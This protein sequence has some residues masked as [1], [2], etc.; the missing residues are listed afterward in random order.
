MEGGVVFGFGDYNT[1][2]VLWLGE[3]GVGAVVFLSVLG[4]AILGLS[5]Y[6]LRPMPALRKYTLLTL[7]AVVYL[8]AVV[9]LLEPAVDLKHVT[10]VKNDIV[11]LFDASAS[12]RLEADGTPRIDLAREAFENLNLPQSG[13]DDEHNYLVYAMESRPRTLPRDSIAD[14]K[15]T[16]SDSGLGNALKW[17]SDEYAR[18]SLGGVVVISDGID[19]SSM[20]TRTKRGEPLDEISLELVK[21]LDAPINT[22]SAG[23]ASDL[24]D[25]AIRKVSHDD[26]AFVHNK[27]SIEVD[28]QVVGFTSTSI[29]VRLE[30]DGQLLQTRDL[31]VEDGKTDYRVT[32]EFVPKRLGREVY[33]VELPVLPG[34]VLQTNN[35]SYFVQRVIRDKIRVLQVVGRPSWDE[36]YLRMFLKR[37][38]NIDLISF[39]ILRTAENPDMAPASEMSL[40]P[41]PTDELFD[42]E[43]G[44][45]DLI[46]FQ[47]FNFGPYNMLRYLPNIEKFVKDG[48]GFVMVGGDLSFASGG[49]AG[50]PIED[51]LPVRLPANSTNAIDTGEFRPLLTDAGRRHPITQLAFDP[52][53]NDE[54]WGSLPPQLGTN[55]VMGPKKDATVLATHPRLSAEGKPMPVITVSEYGDGR[56]MALTTDATWRWAFTN[57]ANGGTSREYQ[58]LWN[59]TM[60]WLIQD[61]ELKLLRLDLDDEEVN[62]GSNATG[63]VKVSNPDYTPA[64]GARGEVVVAWRA[65]EDL[66][67]T[68]VVPEVIQR[69]PLETDTSGLFRL[70]LKTPKTGLYTVTAQVETPNGTLTD[71]ELFIATDHAQEFRNIIPREDLMKSLATASDGAHHELPAAIGSL[72]FKSP[73][74]VKINRRRVIQIW[75]SPPLFIL[76]LLLLGVEW[77]LRRRWGRL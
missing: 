13:S 22:L 67:K 1:S 38:P 35:V 33:K 36:R 76:V 7:R 65:F 57:A 34:E 75:D 68:D 69:I 37:S 3:W 48:G 47:N 50:T 53:A 28:V 26:F 17:I 40:I 60:R 4:I 25:V 73:T 9:I 64:P 43:L 66:G 46:V 12:M 62:T 15:A 70:D 74:E 41:F 11:V 58:M 72:N 29:P 30:R 32:F 71:A 55:L 31:V 20:G 56:V 39:F 10:K 2:D 61:P 52:D 16:S 5:A 49:Y 8:I 54:L 19:S 44:S 51:M 18:K 42:T 6:D 14:I 24:R 59:N 63:S 23:T 27:V 21:S 45:F 77:T